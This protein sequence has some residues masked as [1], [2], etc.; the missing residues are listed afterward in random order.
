MRPVWPAVDSLGCKA[1]LAVLRRAGTNHQIRGRNIYDEASLQARDGTRDERWFRA[2]SKHGS[3]IDDTK[4]F[5]G[6]NADT[7]G[8]TSSGDDSA[9]ELGP[10]AVLDSDSVVIDD[11]V[12]LE[13]D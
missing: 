12:S 3:P 2:C 8:T 5:P 1:A 13:F 6:P 10:S 11:P 4:D 7:V 9:A